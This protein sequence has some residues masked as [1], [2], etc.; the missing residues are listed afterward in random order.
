MVFVVSCLKHYS[1]YNVLYKYI[2]M[3]SLDFL[4]NMT[5]FLKLNILSFLW[6]PLVRHSCR[7]HLMQDY[8]YVSW[9]IIRSAVFVF[10]SVVIKRGGGRKVTNIYSF[11]TISLSLSFSDS[12]F[13]ALLLCGPFCIFASHGSETDQPETSGAQQCWPQ[14]G[15][16]QIFSNSVWPPLGWEGEQVDYK[17]T[18]ALISQLPASPWVRWGSS[19]WRWISWRSSWSVFF[20]R[21]PGSLSPMRNYFKAA[22]SGWLSFA[23]LR[24]I[25]RPL[26][27]KRPWLAGEWD[28]HGR[29]LPWRSRQ[30]LDQEFK[31]QRR[32][33]DG[34]TCCSSKVESF[35]TGSTLFFISLL[36]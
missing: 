23:S 3:L 6:F 11:P 33:V 15:Q 31:T 21:S 35:C 8:I 2:D 36:N 12:N 13:I 18:G 22:S 14:S 32:S 5:S 30:G 10:H 9:V 17:S 28:L 20:K 34:Q 16:H 25:M 26:A 24:S 27:D 19:P 7:H 1:L 29:L 4:I